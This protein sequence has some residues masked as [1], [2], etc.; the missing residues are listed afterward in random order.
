MKLDTGISITKTMLI[1]AIGNISALRFALV[2]P[3]LVP[4]V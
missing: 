1:A 3:L 2:H 4:T